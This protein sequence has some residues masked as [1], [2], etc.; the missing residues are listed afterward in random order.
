VILTPILSGVAAKSAWAPHVK[1]TH[2]PLS[3]PPLLSLPP[4]SHSSLVGRPRGEAGE[5]EGGGGN[6]DTGEGRVSPHV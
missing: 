4:L 3:S 6:D 2:H 1:V 5:L